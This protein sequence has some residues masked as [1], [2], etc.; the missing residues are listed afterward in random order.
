LVN[1]GR[2]NKSVKYWFNLA[3]YS[4]EI[5]THFT[6]IDQIVIYSGK[7]QFYF[8]HLNIFVILILINACTSYKRLVTTSWKNVLVNVE[9]YIHH[10]EAWKSDCRCWSLPLPSRCVCRLVRGTRPDEKEKEKPREICC[11][12]DN[13][14]SKETF[15]PNDYQSELSTSSSSSA[16]S[17]DTLKLHFAR[18]DFWER[19]RSDRRPNLNW[20]EKPP[21]RREKNSCSFLL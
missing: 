21:A 7:V 1:K 13:L 9:L 12:L 8:E 19:S 3:G 6:H 2:E 16:Q 4:V 14:K 20:T 11:H 10:P 17:F 15:L 18:L 5:S